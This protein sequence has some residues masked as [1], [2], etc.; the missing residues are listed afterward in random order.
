MSPSVVALESQLPTERCPWCESVILR[1]KFL[2]IQTRIADQ[3]RR[4]LAE[5]RARIEARVMEE[6]AHK[7]AVIAAERDRAA[8][9]LKEIEAREATVR[10]Q[11]A[12]EAEARTRAEV[13]TTLAAATVERDRA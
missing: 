4:K 2:Q 9:K 12:A 11:A 6:A 1:S 3:E 5:E 13:Q 7:M 8:S 10:Q